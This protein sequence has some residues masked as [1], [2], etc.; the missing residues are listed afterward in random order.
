MH[1][2][3]S[4]HAYLIFVFADAD[5]HQPLD[6][7]PLVGN[8]RVQSQHAPI[9]QA[10]LPFTQDFA[11]GRDRVLDKVNKDPEFPTVV[12]ASVCSGG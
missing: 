2:S 11:L 5:A 9:V 1:T 6:G 7:S 10:F 4:P 12:W 3:L 8:A